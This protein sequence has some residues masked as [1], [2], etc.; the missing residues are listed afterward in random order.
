[1]NVAITRAQ[2][3]LIVIGN[4]DTLSL[5]KN[6][7]KFIE[8][9]DDNDAVIGEWVKPILVEKLKADDTTHDN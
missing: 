3:L 7:S 8:F 2:A 4:P 6:W 5:D 9:C 1:M